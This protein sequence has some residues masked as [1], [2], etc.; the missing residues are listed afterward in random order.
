MYDGILRHGLRD[1]IEECMNDSMDFFPE[2]A[3]DLQFMALALCGET[4]E[5]ANL[6]KKV[7]R[8][9]HRYT[10]LEEKIKEEAIDSFI[11]LLIIFGLTGVDPIEEYRVKRGNN[12]NRFPVTTGRGRPS[13]RDTVRREDGSG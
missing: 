8:G 11:Y 7:V 4:G 9:S 5:L 3:H 6:V 10:E 1:L 2:V 12:V 13:L